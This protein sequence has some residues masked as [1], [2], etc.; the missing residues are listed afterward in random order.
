MMITL[1]GRVEGKKI[2]REMGGD[3]KTT[4]ESGQNTA[5]LSAALRE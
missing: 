4:Y 2:E 3:G 1:E 5:W